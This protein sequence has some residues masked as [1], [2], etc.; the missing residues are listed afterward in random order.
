MTEL[1][2]ISCPIFPEASCSGSSGDPEGGGCIVPVAFRVFFIFVLFMPLK[3]VF[4]NR[5]VLMCLK[6]E[7]GNSNKLPEELS[8]QFVLHPLSSLVSRAVTSP[9]LPLHVPNGHSGTSGFP[10]GAILDGRQSMTSCVSIISRS[11]SGKG[12]DLTPAMLI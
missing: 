8:L 9:C 11:C 12:N 2:E 10:A 5:P 4:N 6:G 1:T 7:K 3:W